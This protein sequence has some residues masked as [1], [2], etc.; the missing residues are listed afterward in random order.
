MVTAGKN[1]DSFLISNNITDPVEISEIKKMF[2]K[3]RS[4]VVNTRRFKD[5]YESL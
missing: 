1:I 4:R 5:G 2:G 3:K